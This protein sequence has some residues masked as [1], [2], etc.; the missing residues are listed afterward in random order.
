M[1]N[2][3][4]STPSDAALYPLR[5]HDTPHSGDAEIGKGDT[6]AT[7]ELADGRKVRMP[8]P[9]E[10]ILRE[11][12]EVG[13]IY[14]ER[15]PIAL[16]EQLEDIVFS[17]DDVTEAAPDSSSASEKAKSPGAK[18]G[19]AETVSA[20]GDPE[21]AE[22]V[23]KR[24][25]RVL[26]TGAIFG[27]AALAGL[28]FLQSP[29][30]DFSSLTADIGKTITGAAH[31][32]DAREL[33]AGETFR[34]L[35]PD[36]AEFYSVDVDS[37][38]N[39]LIAGRIGQK[40]LICSYSFNSKQKGCGPQIAMRTKV[41][42]GL[43]DPRLGFT[44]AERAKN[45]KRLK[46]E[47]SKQPG[48]KLYFDELYSSET[49]PG[50]G[51]IFQKAFSGGDALAGFTPLSTNEPTAFYRYDP[52]NQKATRIEP[53]ELEGHFTAIARSPNYLALLE[54][55]PLDKDKQVS[56]VFGLGGKNES[57]STTRD[58]NPNGKNNTDPLVRDQ[59]RTFAQIAIRELDGG[60]PQVDLTGR[61]QTEYR[62]NRG[63]HTRVPLEFRGDALR[64]NPKVTTKFHDAETELPEKDRKPYLNNDFTLTARAFN[65]STG[66]TA[67]S[68]KMLTWVEGAQG[69][70]GSQ[71][72]R[73]DHL[74]RIQSSGDKTLGQLVIS[75]DDFPGLVE[76]SRILPL[77]KGRFLLL[78]A[79]LKSSK[80]NSAILIIDE[81]G[82]PLRQEWSSSAIIRDVVMGGDGNVYA[83]GSGKEDGKTLGILKRYRPGD[84]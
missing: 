35:S 46:E 25:T 39:A 16:I 21:A 75:G 6:L 60:A 58:W 72:R 45:L 67:I 30:N 36:G 52:A 61:I 18:A 77:S 27:V 68:A 81:S 57:F 48:G 38:G 62:I 15:G 33:G 69:Q 14:T 64:V 4:I 49:Y 3:K 65:P 80:K 12:P 71:K 70:S 41:N 40:G 1:P 22:P 2:F 63:I 55:E 9:L 7:L 11:V 24:R 59:S 37:Q 29:S 78:I 20:G 79:D 54:Q 73:Q 5:V 84:L 32:Q 13:R 47:M 17:P 10:G 50:S 66:T 31:W 44:E 53:V 8:C 43:D 28:Y 19:P 56:A 23:K 74:V 51:F 76:V 82:R 34:L 26:V 83:V 42:P